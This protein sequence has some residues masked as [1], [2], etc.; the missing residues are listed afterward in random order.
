MA[1]VVLRSCL[2]CVP[3]MTDFGRPSKRQKANTE[4]L[5]F[6]QNHAETRSNGNCRR[7]SPTGGDNKKGNK[8]E[9]EVTNKEK[10]NSR[11]SGW[12]AVYIPP[13]AKYAMDGAPEQLRPLQGNRRSL[14]DDMQRTGNGNDV[15]NIGEAKGAKR[16]GLRVGLSAHKFV[17]LMV[18]DGHRRRRGSRR[19]HRRLHRHRR[20]NCRWGYS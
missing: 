19:L 3:S 13:I 2:K 5:S 17:T 16:K 15:E 11:V 20:G 12:L 6:A 7:R 8:Q 14:R 10:G 1:V 4:I 18:T 9:R